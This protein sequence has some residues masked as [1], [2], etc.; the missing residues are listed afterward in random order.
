MAQSLVDSLSGD[1]EIDQFED[2]YRK[3]VAELIEYKRENGGKRPA[4]QPAAEDDGDDMTDLLTALRRSVEAAGGKAAETS[5]EA[6]EAPAD[7]APAKEAPAAQA[8]AAESPA[9]E[10]PPT[11]KAAAKKSTTSSSGTKKSSTRRKKADE[12]TD[13]KESRTA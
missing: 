8:P 1:F 5:S 3:A 7:E 6:P 10:K 11:K 9:E 2:E 4:P 13:E 12:E